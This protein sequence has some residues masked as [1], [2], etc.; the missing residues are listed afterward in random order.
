MTVSVSVS[1]ASRDESLGTSFHVV[2]KDAFIVSLFWELELLQEVCINTY[3][4]F[5]E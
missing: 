2:L 3:Y 5:L 1:G 4:V